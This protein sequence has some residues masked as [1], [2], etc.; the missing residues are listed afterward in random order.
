MPRDIEDKLAYGLGHNSRD[1]EH[2]D[3]IMVQE[4]AP[5]ISCLKRIPA[6]FLWTIQ[7][8]HPK[9]CCRAVS[10]LTMETYKTTEDRER[11]NLYVFRC[12]CG[13]K[14]RRL[15]MDTGSLT[16]SMPQTQRK[17]M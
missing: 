6:S 2:A 16:S 11:E 14:H 5:L 13:D 10:N 12:R 9:E 7:T 8:E 15:I 4:P 3:H 1:D 17:V